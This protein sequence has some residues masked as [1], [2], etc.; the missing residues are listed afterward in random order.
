M[1]VRA[2]GVNIFKTLRLR[3]HWADVD[4]TWQVY[5]IGHGAKP[6]GSGIL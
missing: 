3:D 4:E 5:S 6:Q 2:F 1:S